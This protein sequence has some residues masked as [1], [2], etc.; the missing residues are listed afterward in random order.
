[1]EGEGLAITSTSS[2]SN[3][4]TLK[5]RNPGDHSKS[6]EKM[7]AKRCVVK[8]EAFYVNLIHKMAISY[9]LEYDFLE[10]ATL[11]AMESNM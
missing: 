2:R 3:S 10:S 5:N 1:M 7:E 6:V 8:S 9:I 4:E 11:E